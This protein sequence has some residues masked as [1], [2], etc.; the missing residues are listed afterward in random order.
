MGVLM[1]NS[2]L[3][4]EQIGKFQD[5]FTKHD[6]T[7]EGSI[8]TLQLRQ[9]LREIGQNPTEAELQDMVNEVDKDGTGSIDFPEFLTMMGIKVNEENAEGEIR[10][11]FRVFDGDGNG[12]IDRREL[13]LI[14][15]FMG[16]ALTER[17]IQMIIDEADVD[18]DGLIDYTEFFSMM[19]PK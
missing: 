2:I 9:V 13:G 8:D 10:E 6:T 12:F 4:S 7:G 16:E 1:E 15:K 18:H 5:A 19:N 3:T 11:A 17:E 14:M